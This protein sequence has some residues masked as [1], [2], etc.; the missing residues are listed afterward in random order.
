RRD[1]PDLVRRRPPERRRPRRDR[2]VP[3]RV[4]DRL[5]LPAGGR[6]QAVL[7]VDERAP[8]APGV[9]EPPAV[10][11]LVVTRLEPG[12]PAALGVVGPPAVHVDVD[13]AAARAPGADGLRAVEVPHAHLEAEVAVGQGAD[14]TDVHHVAGVRV[15]ERT[16]REEADL[17]VIAAL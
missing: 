10:D 12:H 1:D 7:V 4:A 3:R 11:G 14:G 6:E 8:V 17:R 5:A 13:V 15:L 9:A 16:T 2:L